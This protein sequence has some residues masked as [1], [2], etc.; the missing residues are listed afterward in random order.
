MKLHPSQ[1][2]VW[3]KDGVIRFRQNA[4]VAYLYEVAAK[5]GA[6]LNDLALLPF[7]VADRTQLAQL[8]GYSV[9]GF[10]ELSYVSPRAQRDAARRAERMV[11][12]RKETK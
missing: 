1:R 6:S 9:G 8:T 3:T 11:A 4:I 2:L 7:S 10:C 12:R 5:H